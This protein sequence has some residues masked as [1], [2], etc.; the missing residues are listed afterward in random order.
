MATD[1][2]GSKLWA[3]RCV[4]A[5]AAILLAAVSIT[6]PLAVSA[7]SNVAASTKKLDQR[8]TAI[9]ANRF[10]AADGHD[11]QRQIDTKAAAAN[12][13]AQWQAINDKLNEIH[14]LVVRL[15]ERNA[16]AHPAALGP[17]P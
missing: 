14:R 16:A 4:Q 2:N 7:V 15:E 5:L 9:E 6:T 17:P 8:I 10:T 1:S 13:A 12:C 11:L 3:W